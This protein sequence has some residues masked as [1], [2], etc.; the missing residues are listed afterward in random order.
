[1]VAIWGLDSAKGASLNLLTLL[2]SFLDQKYC[3][4]VLNGVREVNF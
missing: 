1:L 3:G 4:I 2:K